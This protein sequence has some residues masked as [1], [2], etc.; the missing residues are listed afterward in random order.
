MNQPGTVLLLFH[1]GERKPL[2][3]EVRGQNLAG[4]TEGETERT[5]S[6]GQL[7]ASRCKNPAARKNRGASAQNNRSWARGCRKMSILKHKRGTVHYKQG[8]NHSYESPV[9]FT[10]AR[11]NPAIGNTFANECSPVLVMKC[12][13]PGFEVQNRSANVFLDLLSI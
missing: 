5:W 6:G 9:E 4:R 2:G 7:Y 13:W 8:S 11:N 12:T 10:D 1:D 3:P